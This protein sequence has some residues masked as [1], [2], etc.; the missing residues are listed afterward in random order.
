MAR[1]AARRARRP[2]WPAASGAALSRNQTRRPTWSGFGGSAPPLVVDERLY[3]NLAVVGV[4]T[5]CPVAF[6]STA[7]GPSQARP[8]AIATA[9]R[10][11]PYQASP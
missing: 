2:G 5:C 3:A 9:S 11:G 8:R 7:A 10:I 6:G 1:A 4:G